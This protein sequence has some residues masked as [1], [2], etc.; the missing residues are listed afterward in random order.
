MTAATVDPPVRRGSTPGPGMTVVVLLG[1][2]G[3]GKGTQAVL[4]A[5]RLAVPHVATGDLFRA[6]VRDGSPI[7]LEARRYMERGQLVP[8]DITIRMLLD[9]LASRCRRRA[10]SS[11]ASR[12]TGAQAEAL[13]ASLAERGAEGRPRRLHRGRRPTSSSGGCRAAGCAATPATSTT[14]RPTRR[15]SPGQLRPRRLAARPARGRQGRDHPGAARRAARQ[16]ARGGRLLPR[17]SGVL[18][19]VDGVQ[20]ID[21]VADAICCAHA[22]P[23][24]PVGAGLTW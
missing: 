17:D 3:A 6:A 1:A 19:T 24:T 20:P 10:S 13:D 12:A 9:R 18:R 21:E 7:G 23:T 16:P 22:R 2:P 14:R 8:D 15:G 4:L 5:E 11:M